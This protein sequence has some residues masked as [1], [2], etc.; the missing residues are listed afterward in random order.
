MNI[1]KV[2]PIFNSLIIKRLETKKETDSGFIL[3]TT[4]QKQQN[5]ALVKEIGPECKSGIKAGDY[6]IIPNGNFSATSVS[7]E[8]EDLL[9]IEENIVVAIINLSE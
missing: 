9:I 6:I 5:V 4:S 7:V 3:P 2:K 8:G 1:V